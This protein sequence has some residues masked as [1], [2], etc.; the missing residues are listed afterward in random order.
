MKMADLTHEH[1]KRCYLK[2]LSYPKLYVTSS[3]ST[4]LHRMWTTSALHESSHHGW[5]MCFYW[6]RFQN[7]RHFW[8]LDRRFVIV[9]LLT[10]H[11]FGNFRGRTRWLGLQMFWYTG[12]IKSSLSRTTCDF[13][14]SFSCSLVCSLNWVSFIKILFIITFITCTRAII[15]CTVS[16]IFSSD[17]SRLCMTPVWSIVFRISIGPTEIAV[18]IFIMFS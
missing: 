18:F 6:N 17:C 11:V 15:N 13:F 1:E 8:W 10:W 16:W 7:N 9:V 5:L 4:W 14:T 12:G 3:H 2:K